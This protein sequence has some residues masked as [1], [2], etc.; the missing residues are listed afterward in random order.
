MKNYFGKSH[1]SE[2]WPKIAKKVGIFLGHS[3]QDCSKRTLVYMGIFFYWSNTKSTGIKVL[4]LTITIFIT[5]IRI[6]AFGD[7]S[8]S[9]GHETWIYR[10]IILNV[11]VKNTY[12]NRLKN[13]SWNRGP[14]FE[15]RVGPPHW[16]I[17]HCTILEITIEKVLQPRCYHA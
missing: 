7:F 12:L 14:Y 10:N 8:G 2:K 9:W 5:K 3:V 17:R 1:V 6:V 15:E 4:S 16:L 13:Y 11:N